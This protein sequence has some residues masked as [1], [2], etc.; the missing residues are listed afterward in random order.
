M[1]IFR[2]VDQLYQTDQFDTA[3]VRVFSI[4]VPRHDDDHHHDDI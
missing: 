4:I 2:G 3:G 1:L